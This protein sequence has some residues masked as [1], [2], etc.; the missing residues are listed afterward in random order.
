M[1]E[2]RRHA[3]ILWTLY[4]SI[5]MV[6]GLGSLGLLCLLWLPPALALQLILPR[7]L[8]QAI[9]RRVISAGFRLYLRI[10]SRLCACRLDLSELDS[11]RHQGPLIVAANHPSLLDAVLIVSRLPNAIC[12]MKASLMDNPLLGAAARLAGYVRNNGALPMITNSRDSLAEG[13]QLV[14][15]PEGSRTQR[16][17]VDLFTP[18]LGLIAWRSGVAVQ[19]VF[20]EFST[21]YLGKNWPLFRRPKLPLHCRARLGQ[22]FEAMTDHNRFTDELEAYFR[23]EAQPVWTKS[24]DAHV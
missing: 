6:V 24:N 14:M 3:S 19:T 2:Q 21:P 13:A 16:F 8:G 10:L 22:R 9:G 1:S 7:R 15:F 11:L 20:L 17:P 23:R 18:S 5:A 12:V 4:E